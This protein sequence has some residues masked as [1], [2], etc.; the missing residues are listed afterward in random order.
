MFTRGHVYGQCDRFRDPFTL[1]AIGV[2][3]AA[4]ALMMM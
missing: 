1:M 4:I 3:L 2:V